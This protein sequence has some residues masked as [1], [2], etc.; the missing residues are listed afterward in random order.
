MVT[1]GGRIREYLHFKV[2]V[3]RGWH[4]IGFLSVEAGVN[5]FSHNHEGMNERMNQ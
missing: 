3:A 5:G 4:F 2:V 1:P